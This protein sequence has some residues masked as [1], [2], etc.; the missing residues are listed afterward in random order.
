MCQIA[1][2]DLNS[3]QMSLNV[4]DD[5]KNRCPK[6][7]VHIIKKS[8]WSSSGGMTDFWY[9][10]WQKQEKHIELSPIHQ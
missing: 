4:T 1:S 7:K 3:S 8:H 6:E 9:L 5:T 2:V 10:E